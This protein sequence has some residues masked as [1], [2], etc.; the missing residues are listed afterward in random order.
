MMEKD[1][2][3]QEFQ[4][5]KQSE[6]KIID[7]VDV[8][9]AIWNGKLLILVMMI[10]FGAVGP[11]RN[12]VDFVPSYRTSVWI[13]IPQY[14]SKQ[15]VNTVLNTARGDI[16]RDTCKIKNIDPDKNI[17]TVS[18]KLLENSYVIIVSYEGTEPELIKEFSDIHK[19]LYVRGINPYINQEI[20]VSAQLKAL[21]A[22]ITIQTEDVEKNVLV[23]E[24]K[25]I[26]D[27]A[28]PTVVVNQP[29]WVV[30]S[31]KYALAGGV[32]GCG[33]CVLRYLYKLFCF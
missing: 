11:I 9:K 25:I 16:Y 33:L 14:A 10:L 32:L 12:Y 28:V 22:G 15:T 8:F 4:K 3:K 5:D 30:N 23:S 31:I 29:E 26:K 19:E 18:T 7:L 17:V 1:N 2:E 21:E 6:I 24:A 27:S 20:I 13:Q